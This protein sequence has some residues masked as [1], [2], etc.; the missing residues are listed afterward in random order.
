MVKVKALLEPIVS[1]G[2]ALQIGSTNSYYLG[3]IFQV[4]F[5]ICKYH[6]CD[7]Q[8]PL[9][10]NFPVFLFNY[11]N[12][13][14]Q[15]PN[16]NY[17]TYV[18]MFNY[19]SYFAKTWKALIALAFSSSEADSK[20]Q[21]LA[22]LAGLCNISIIFNYSG[23]ISLS[24]FNKSSTYCSIVKHQRCHYISNVAHQFGFF[25]VRVFVIFVI[26]GHFVPFPS[27]FAGLKK[28]RR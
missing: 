21:G 23:I 8:I 1:G 5:P 19:N 2:I 3:N 11:F 10:F 6:F 7:L 28:R 27:Y 15:F 4:I 13:I 14:T 17:C 18:A 9:I 22:S 26:P 20:C 24:F 25:N 12:H 16:V